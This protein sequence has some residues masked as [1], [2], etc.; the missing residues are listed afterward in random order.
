MFSLNKN[1]RAFLP[2]LC[3]LLLSIQ[4]IESF[5]VGSRAIKRSPSAARVP[6]NQLS[7]RAEPLSILNAKKKKTVEEKTE[8]EERSGFG[9]FL[10][11]MTPWRNPNSIFV[12]MFGVLYCLG[13][14]S[15]AQS[16]ARDAGVL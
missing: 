16:I 9:L 3:L 10:V 1:I 15:E 6:S 13:K 11:Y 8:K 14:Y 2:V 7:N 12:Y 4:G 5:E